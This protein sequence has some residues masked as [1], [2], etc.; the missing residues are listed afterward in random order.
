MQTLRLSHI[1]HMC[2]NARYTRVHVS[3]ISEIFKNARYML[4]LEC[5]FH[6]YRAYLICAKMRDICLLVILIVDILTDD[7]LCQS[8]LASFTIKMAMKHMPGIDNIDDESN[9]IHRVATYAGEIALRSL[10]NDVRTLVKDAVLKELIPVI[11]EGGLD[12]AS[13]RSRKRALI[14]W[15]KSDNPLSLDQDSHPALIEAIVKPVN[16]VMALKEPRPLSISLTKFVEDIIAHATSLNPRRKPPFISDGQ[17][18]Y[19]TRAAIREVTSFAARNGSCTEKETQTMI[20][21]G[22]IT[23]CHTL[24]I[25]QVPWSVPHIEG[26]GASRR[27][28]ATS[29]SGIALD[30]GAPVVIGLEL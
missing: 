1:S 7:I 5:R 27:S 14:R 9:P 23:G 25:N 3:R 29:A 19:V 16:G 21:D 2:Q 4:A 15:F 17:F 8:Y 20:R 13:A 10:V 6:A 28:E 18:I 11:E 30:E 22:F 24:K 26:G 12:A